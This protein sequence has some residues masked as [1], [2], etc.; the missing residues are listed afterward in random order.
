MERTRCIYV[1]SA[2]ETAVCRWIADPVSEGRFTVRK[3]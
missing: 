3:E 1:Y 2:D